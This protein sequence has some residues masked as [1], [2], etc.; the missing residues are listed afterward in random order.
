MSSKKDK[1]LES[2]QKFIIKGQIDKAVKDLEQAIALDP[3]DIKVRQRLAEL[4]VRVNRQEEAI[5]EYETI[6]KY[7]ADSSFFLKAIAFYK[8]IQRLA[9]DNTRITLTLADLNVKQGLTGNALAEFNQ[10]L[11]GYLKDGRHGEALKVLERMREVDPANLNTLLKTAETFHA[12]NQP[13]EAYQYYLQ[14]AQQLM[15]KADKTPLTQLCDR[16]SALYPNKGS[17]ILNLVSAQ[18]QR[19]E[20]TP[21]LATLREIIAHDSTNLAAWYLLSDALRTSGDSGQLRDILTLLCQRFPDECRPREELIELAIATGD[22]EQALEILAAFRSFLLANGRGEALER[23]YT[24]LHDQAPH[25]TRPLEGLAWLHAETGDSDKLAAVNAHLA[26]LA[27]QET[28]EEPAAGSPDLSGPDDEALSPFLTAPDDELANLSAAPERKIPLSATGEDEPIPEWEEEI[29]LG[30]DDD[31]PAS[32]PETETMTS[33][34]PSPEAGE[35]PAGEPFPIPDIDEGA[36]RF[37]DVLPGAADETLEPGNTEDAME[38]LR[39][40]LTILDP[41]PVEAFLLPEEEPI[42][43]PFVQEEPEQF[44]APENPAFDWEATTT[45]IDALISS[46]NLTEDGVAA[47][48]SFEPVQTSGSAGPEEA[49]ESLFSLDE[50]PDFRDFL[51]ESP[52]TAQGQES[53]ASTGKYDLDDLFTAFKKGVGEQLDAT[54]TESHYDLG[55]AY[56]EMGLF[57]DAV[58]E[59]RAASVDPARAAD[60]ACLEGICWR[61]KGDLAAAEEAFSKGLQLASLSTESRLNLKYELAFLYECLD[62]PDDAITLYREIV[63]TNPGLRDSQLRLYKLGGDEIQDLLDDE[64]IELE[65]DKES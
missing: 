25:D 44:Q 21:A 16:I 13:E 37:D 29:D 6:G 43:P 56:R 10:L 55:I 63:L 23:F 4:L 15:G 3:G 57:D 40:T 8:Q 31:M 33:V 46:L 12:A 7:F 48:E 54:D 17:I 52:P 61:D 24:G 39:V 58:A 41:L 50:I 49:G 22:L 26:I 62:R 34:E 36:I 30:I 9:P 27:P 60:C 38:P 14:L 53:Q 32:L 20:T 51:Q 35:V 42:Q 2:A 45:G 11:N 5:A 59:F 19:G 28:A 1:F 18:I 64:L 65:D 47:D